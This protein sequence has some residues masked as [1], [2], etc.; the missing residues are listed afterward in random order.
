MKF[1]RNFRVQASLSATMLELVLSL[2]FGVV[3]VSA[4]M[5]FAPQAQAVYA[6]DEIVFWVIAIWL[7]WGAFIEVTIM[8]KCATHFYRIIRARVTQPESIEP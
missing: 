1:D 7:A 6:K 5:F 2:I 3:V 4:A 8:V